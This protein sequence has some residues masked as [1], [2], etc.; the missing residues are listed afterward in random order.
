MAT[1]LEESRAQLLSTAAKSVKRS[2]GES[3][4]LLLDRYYRHMLTEDLLARRPED[5]VGA[6]VSHRS[7]AQERPVGKPKVRVFTPSV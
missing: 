4:E 1:S 5:L 6:A 7:L 2:A 3:A